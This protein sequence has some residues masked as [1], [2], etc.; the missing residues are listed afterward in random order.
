MSNNKRSATEITSWVG[1]ITTAW[2]KSIDAV[3][4]TGDLLIAAKAKLPHGK[5]LAMVKG[6]L[7]FSPRVAQILMDVARSDNLRSVKAKHA[8]HLPRSLFTL[9][10][11]AR[12]PDAAFDKFII[13]GDITVETTRL[14]AEQLYQRAIEKIVEK[15]P[16]TTA[17]PKTQYVTVEVTHTTQRYDA[18]GYVKEPNERP[19][20]PPKI[21][22]DA[23]PEPPNDLAVMATFIG[24]EAGTRAIL[25]AAR[26]CL[27]DIDI[28]ADRI[29]P[30]TQIEIVE[31]CKKAI[32][33]LHQIIAR[34]DERRGLSVVEPPR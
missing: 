8:S 23:E 26:K 5:F 21:T 29:G 25:N 30:G 32:S 14:Q 3:F 20:N 2:Q 28:A 6:E 24:L 1:R 16:T 4:E 13:S 15:L 12:L 7:P 18:V 27:A 31:R 9:D 22:L 19:V 10:V 11:L 34:V 17:A 33:L